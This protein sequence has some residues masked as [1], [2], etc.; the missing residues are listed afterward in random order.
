MTQDDGN[1]CILV[2]EEVD[3]KAEFIR[4]VDLP[5]GGWWWF[6]GWAKDDEMK[7]TNVTEIRV[8]RL[9]VD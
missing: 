7:S 6:F 9:V 2:D 5:S 3:R 1:C 4:K 8:L